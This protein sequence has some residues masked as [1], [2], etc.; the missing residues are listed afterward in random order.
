[1]CP[2]TPSSHQSSRRHLLVLCAI[3]VL[4]LL[5]RLP[6]LDW[7]LPHVYE[8]AVPLKHAWTM[9]GWG[10]RSVD[11][12]PHFFHYPSLAFYAQLAGQGVLYAGMKIAGAVESTRDFR[13]IYHT[14]PTAF[15]RMGRMLAVLL[16]LLT[17]AL[18]FRLGFE[19]GGAWVGA[20]ACLLLALNIFHVSRSQMIEVDVPLTAFVVLALVLLVRASSTPS[21]RGYVLAGIAIGLAT[22][23]KYTGLLLVIPLVVA[24]IVARRKARAP[25]SWLVGS[26]LV[27]AVAFVATSPYVLLDFSA[28]R[29]DLAL[30]RAHMR[31]GHFGGSDPAWRFYPSR[32]GASLVG[33]PALALAA[34]GIAIA[35]KRR[36]AWAWVLLSLVVAYAL[37]IAS[38]TVTADRYAL[39]LL[40]GVMLF[41][42]YGAWSVCER[43]VK[44]GMLRATAMGALV[45]IMIAVLFPGLA[46]HR[47]RSSGDS[48][49]RA[50]RWIERNIPPGSLVVTEAYGAP[51]F[52]PLEFWE[53][54]G[55]IRKPVY[56]I[57]AANG[58]RGVLPIPLFQA[59]PEQT[60]PYYDITLYGMADVIVTTG[61]VRGR[62]ARDPERFPTQ[63]TFYDDLDHRFEWVHTVDARGTGPEIRIHRTRVHSKPFAERGPGTLQA[64]RNTDS[65]PPR[66]QAWYY[67]RVGLNCEAFG[68]LR[69]AV[70]AYE[71]AAPHVG[72]DSE[73]FRQ[74]AYGL[75]RSY[76]M[77]RQAERARRVIDAM[78]ETAPSASDR[79][80]VESLRSGVR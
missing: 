26:A 47:E 52:G 40:P 65:L 50:L 36:A 61:A 19:A 13:I 8:E 10:D 53:I 25:W 62:Y 38:W 74:V 35:L 41:A 14:D 24:H 58:F 2:R 76:T 46:A 7:G 73:T 29:A 17:V 69:D 22:A 64:L 54:A 45:A 11:L 63:A 67:Y 79:E 78:A 15:Y 1:M 48:R 49:T 42:A 43:L 60:A 28:F 23:T 68:H 56:D 21:L 55:D 39:P 30:E 80:F 16:A 51:L 72:G 44:T 12:N 31:L 66:W 27:A 32:L 4:A 59:E 18:L 70:R 71:M 57:R 75:V 37:A 3:V 33:W 9:G 5:V 77:L 34:V 20:G 6:G